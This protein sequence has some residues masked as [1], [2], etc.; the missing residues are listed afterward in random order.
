MITSAAPAQGPPGGGPPGGGAPPIKCPVGDPYFDID[1]DPLQV[2]GRPQVLGVRACC[3]DDGVCEV[4]EEYE[5]NKALKAW[6]SRDADDP[7][8]LAPEIN[9]SQ[10]PDAQPGASNLTLNFVE[11]ISNPALDTFDAGKYQLNLLDD[12]D[13]RPAA[14]DITGISAVLT[15]RPFA[16][17][18]TDIM[19]D[20]V[21]NP[22]ET[23]PDGDIFTATGSAFEATV[24]AYL[25]SAADDTDDDG[26]P[27]NGAD[28]TD[29]GQ[30]PAFAWNTSVTAQL[31]TP[32]AGIGGVL[33]EFSGGNIDAGEYSDGA[34]MQNDFAYA[35][36]GS[37][38]L[39]AEVT[40]YL[41]SP[42]V[43][44]SGSSGNIGRFIPF[45]F[46]VT[47][48]IPEFGTA[49]TAGSNGYTYIGEPFTYNIAP[50]LT[51]TARAAGGTT[52]QNYT[53]DF[54]KLTEAK[55]AADGDK[56]YAPANLDT[57]LVP[58]PDPTVQDQ[59]SGI[60]TLTFSD[61]GGL[62]FFR[63]APEAPFEAEISLTI[64][65]IDEDDVVY[66]DGA[67]NSLNPVRVPD[68]GAMD[69]DVSPEQRWGRMVL[70]NAGGSE[71]LD[72]NVPLRVEYYDG[73]GFIPNADDS[74]TA[75]ED[76]DGDILL[77]NPETSGG[78]PQ[79]GDSVM[80]IGAGT[81]Q[82]TSGP[83]AVTSG[84]DDITFSAPGD[85]NTGFVDIEIKLDVDSGSGGSDDPWLQYDW[86]DDGS[87]D[88]NPAGRASFGIYRGSDDLI[89]TREPWD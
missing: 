47:Q 25:W 1:E 33:G 49:C 53:G 68:S 62:T 85:G 42:G 35:E 46:E 72:V 43:S 32:A 12:S 15:V 9:G 18:F 48:N 76:L 39:N 44:V 88:N 59:G 17:G 40:D 19:A 80:T 74:C 4:I 31:Q 13:T 3:D 52:T 82:I 22:G 34:T 70:V 29:N 83:P 78:T 57:A 27:D 56:T 23:T 69:F 37:M 73:T 36:V 6:L 11:G 5:G 24:S 67:G 79:P 63:N 71:L 30:T 8:G 14:P 41:N 60:G 10:L 38:S 50:V 86:D 81:T 2:A 84:E 55:L 66:G 65:V 75:I 77:T 21:A 20:G 61:G 64:N 58:A 7:G 26:L 54:F 45:D 16:L 51:V 89:Y 28:V 87:H